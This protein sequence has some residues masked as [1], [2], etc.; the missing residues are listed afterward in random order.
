MLLGKQSR[1]G[2]V[3]LWRLATHEPKI[4]LDFTHH[5]VAAFPRLGGGGLNTRGA[6][7]LISVACYAVTGVVLSIRGLI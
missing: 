4:D 5:R 7:W 1:L 3:T 2:C 6:S